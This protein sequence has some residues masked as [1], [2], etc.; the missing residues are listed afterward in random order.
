MANAMAQEAIQV[1]LLNKYEKERII[2]QAKAQ[3]LY[4]KT[5]ESQKVATQT[6]IDWVK[7]N[8]GAFQTEEDHI[9]TLKMLEDQLDAIAKKQDKVTDTFK[10]YAL[11]TLQGIANVTNAWSAYGQRQIDMWAQDEKLK[12]KDI[13]NSKQR[14]KELDRID[15]EARNK[16]RDWAKKYGDFLI[17]AAYA[18]TGAA[19]IGALGAK[20]W[21]TLNF[22]QAG[23]V[24]LAGAA[25]IATVTANVSQM[26][27]LAIGGD[28]VTAGPETIMV[29][30]NPG[31]RERVQVTPLSSPNIA[32]PQEG[33]ASITV[34]VSGNLM[35]S[36]YV[37][38]ELAEQIKEAVR[39][40][41][42]FGIS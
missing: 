11:V 31:G 27:K 42:D 24:A 35:S 10:D 3:E 25:Q 4:S 17:G 20:P 26:K 2:R 21:T 7:A 14:Q 5:S 29:G 39:R 8:E 9:A 36:D 34:N 19:V 18:E 12:A 32:G 22:I 33:G 28:F 13:R 1:Q 38:G 15:E 16:K 41:T 37:E 30:D 23:L 40:G 6:M